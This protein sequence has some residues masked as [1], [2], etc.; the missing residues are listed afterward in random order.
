MYLGL[1][2]GPFVSHN[3]ISTQESHVRLLKFQMALR[4]KILMSSG[5]KKGIR[6]FFFLSLKKSRK[7]NPL[8]V[9]QQGPLW[10]DT[11]LQGIFTSLLIYLL[12]S[13]CQSPW[14]L[15]VFL[16][17]SL[18]REPPPCSLTGSPRTGILCHQ[19]HWPSQGILFIHSIMCVCQSPQKGALLHTYRKNI[20]SPSTVPHA[21]RST[22]NG[23]RPGS[24]GGSFMTH[25]SLPQCHAAFGM[26]H[27]TFAW[28]DQSPFSQYV[29]WQPPSGYTLHNCYCIPRDPG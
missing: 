10:R 6:I 1:I 3:L 24:P 23:V 16:S 15:T 27:S 17:E 18:V 26:I 7:T 25:L 28:V 8:Q 21:D 4:L 9:A 22:Y 29:L 11:R 12:L 19:S 5:S 13:F 20:R 14:S 2:D